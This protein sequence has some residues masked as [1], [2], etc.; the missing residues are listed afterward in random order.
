[1]FTLLYRY[2]FFFIQ[3]FLFLV[4][5]CITLTGQLIMDIFQRLMLS[6]S[7]AAPVG[8]QGSGRFLLPAEAIS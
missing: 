8:H 6:C 3:K 4:E 1:M 2:M 5:C 7:S